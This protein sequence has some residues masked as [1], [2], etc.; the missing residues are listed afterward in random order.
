MAVKDKTVGIIALHQHHP[1][2]GQ[3][4]F[5]D[6]GQRHGVGIVGLALGGFRKPV[7]EQRERLLGGGEITGC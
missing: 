2:V 5:V 1:H 4:A 7:A 3:A 6:R